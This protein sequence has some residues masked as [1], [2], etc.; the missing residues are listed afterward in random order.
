MPQHRKESIVLQV[1][2]KRDEININNYRGISVLD[3]TYKALSNI[4][5][6]KSI[7]I[8]HYIIRDHQRGF[9]HNRSTTNQI[10][11]SRQILDK[12]M[13]VKCG[14]ISVNYRF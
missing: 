1:Y 11:C 5:V 4:L 9:R 12:E 3:N 6:S 7:H 2:E 13:G 10:F 8:I 14:R